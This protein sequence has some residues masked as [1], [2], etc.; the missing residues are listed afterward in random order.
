MPAH[1]P[2]IIP[3][4]TMEHHAALKGDYNYAS[5]SNQTINHTSSFIGDA[6]HNS[7]WKEAIDYNRNY[8]APSHGLVNNQTCTSYQFMIKCFSITVYDWSSR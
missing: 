1:F 2:P 8:I 4:T 5:T 7:T 3:I 6:S